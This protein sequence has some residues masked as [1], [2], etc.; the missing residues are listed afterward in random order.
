MTESYHNRI[1]LDH[2]PDAHLRGVGLVA[3]SWAYL[4]GAVERIVWRLARL[5]DKVGASITTHTNIQTRLDA[6]R[7]L[8][9]REFP[10]SDP[11][12]RLKRLDRH[13]RQCLMGDRNEI[14]HSRILHFNNPDLTIRLIYRA[15][16][17]LRKDAKPIEDAE[18]EAVSARILA[19]ATEATDIL[20]RVLD[21]IR[22]KDETAA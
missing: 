13:I 11:A 22:E 9:N 6:A 7:T 10:D 3:I 5:D 19:A 18:Y 20:S 15:R 21:F 4:E 14:V 17:E 8:L 12:V 1:S 2:L 16:G